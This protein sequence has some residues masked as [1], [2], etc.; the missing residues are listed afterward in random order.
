[1]SYAELNGARI[2]YEVAGDGPAVVLLHEGIADARMW[3]P[4]WGALCASY[5]TLRCDMRGFG[6]STLP[7]GSFS[8]SNDVRSVL[9]LA[10]IQSAAFVGA[11]MGANVALELA[12]VAPERVRA[13]VLAPP[14]I[15]GG[16][17]SPALEE[18]GEA[19]D[20]ALERGDVDE[21]V[22][23]NV[24]VWVAGPRRPIEAVD[25]DVVR[26][27]AEMQQRAFDVQVPA[28]EQDPPPAYEKLVDPIA[29]HLG[30]VRV[31]VLVLVGEEDMP[32]IL[33]AADEI[34][35]RVPGARK[36]VMTDTAH[37]PNLERPAEYNEL[38]L[39][40]LADAA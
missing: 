8:I 37:V 6:R 20:A 14:G 22:R 33:T 5:R 17:R 21:A 24:D 4:Q 12:V 39:Q 11:S 1:V 29:D 13:L 40:F 38:V 10:G 35:A 30:D 2:W 27:V 16:E 34:A 3:D 26:A 9:D 28:Y 15:V 23:L 18:Y 31:P 36:V 32:D 7:G 19:E 25:Q